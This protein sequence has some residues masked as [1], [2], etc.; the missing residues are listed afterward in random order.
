M[1]LTRTSSLDLQNIRWLSGILKLYSRSRMEMCSFKP[2]AKFKVCFY[3]ARF[4]LIDTL[5]AVWID[6]SRTTLIC[7]HTLLRK[8]YRVACHQSDH[9]WLEAE[10]MQVT[11]FFKDVDSNGLA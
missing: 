1:P 9:E 4:Q 6:V 3:F 11:A 10:C 2:E 8:I 5:T 7:R